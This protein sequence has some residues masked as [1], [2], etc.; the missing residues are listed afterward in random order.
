LIPS[1][2]VADSGERRVSVSSCDVDKRPY[3]SEAAM[4]R[5]TH[6]DGTSESSR[7][8]RDKKISI[9]PFFSKNQ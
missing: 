3:S 8:M 5:Q 2:K 4:P 9:T 1:V 7:G 6:V